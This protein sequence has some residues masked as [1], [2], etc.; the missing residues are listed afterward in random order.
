MMVELLG[1][2]SP[3]RSN[4]SG[5]RMSFGL[6]QHWRNTMVKDQFAMD[7]IMVPSVIKPGNGTS[8][9]EVFGKIN[10]FLYTH[11][12]YILC[13]ILYIYNIL[14]RYQT[15]HVIMCIRLYK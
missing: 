7:F 1:F 14:I 11:L 2:P 10:V 5:A 8:T 6:D 9:L 4:L 13:N 15:S 3:L 12:M